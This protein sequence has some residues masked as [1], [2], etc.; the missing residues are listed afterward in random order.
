ML[1]ILKTEL[2]AP[3]HATVSSFFLF[4]NF[5]LHESSFES[6]RHHSIDPV[7]EPSGTMKR[8]VMGHIALWLH[9]EF[10]CGRSHC[11]LVDFIMPPPKAGLPFLLLCSLHPIPV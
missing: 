8:G 6:G 1:N 7:G 4:I 10:S 2:C 9:R 5:S 3:C 11:C